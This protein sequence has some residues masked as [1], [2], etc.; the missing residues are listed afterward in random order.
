MLVLAEEPYLV[1]NRVAAYCRRLRSECRII[2]PAKTNLSNLIYMEDILGHLVQHASG[3]LLFAS[4][5]L[6]RQYKSGTSSDSR[7]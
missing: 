1:S 4:M 5:K 2:N 7:K 3:L 6:G